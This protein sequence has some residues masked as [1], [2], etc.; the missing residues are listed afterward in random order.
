MLEI[1]QVLDLTDLDLRPGLPL[2]NL[3][4]NVF[5]YSSVC[6]VSNLCKEEDI[7]VN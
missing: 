6:L 2:T 5:F 7:I 4:K 1:A 3:H